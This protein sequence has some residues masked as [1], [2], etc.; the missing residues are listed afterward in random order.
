MKKQKR[1]YKNLD[2]KQVSGNKV[3]WKNVKPSFSDKSVNF[4]KIILVEKNTIIEDENK[5]AHMMNNY[6]NIT[7]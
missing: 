2:E 7:Y 6:F 4:S 5:I 3:F 1:V